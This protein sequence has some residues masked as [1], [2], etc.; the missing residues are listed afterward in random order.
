M[1]VNSR[2][3]AVGTVFL[4][5][6]VASVYSALTL[7]ESF[8]YDGLGSR[9]LPAIVAG[10]MLLTSIAVIAQGLRSDDLEHH[11]VTLFPVALIGAGLIFMY[12]A[13]MDLGWIITGAVLFCAVARAFGDTSYVKT[14]LLALAMSAATF[15]LF[16]QGLGVSLPLGRVF[17]PLFG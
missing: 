2:Q 13:I 14:G 17:T 7:P 10:G 4:C 9:L 16:T 8:S 1:T 12:F 15:F 5:V 6:G 3:I 11:A